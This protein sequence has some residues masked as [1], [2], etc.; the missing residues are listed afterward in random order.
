MST[1]VFFNYLAY[2]HI[3]ST[4]PLVAELVCRG[5]RVIYYALEEFQATIEDT[6]AIFRSY[7]QDFPSHLT[8]AEF[9]TAMTVHGL[10]QTSKWVLDNLLQEVRAINPDYIA[11][12]AF[13]PWGRYVAQVLQVPTVSIVSGLLMNTR[14]LCSIPSATLDAVHPLVTRYKYTARSQALA[15][16]L[17]K[18][19]RF[20]K[21]HF[22]EVLS[23]KGML[24]IVYTSKLFQPL[25]NSFDHRHFKFV[26][27]PILPRPKT[28]SFPFEALEKKPLIY[29]SLGTI[30]NKRE[31]FYRM[32]FEAFADKD[33]QIVMAIGHSVSRESLGAVPANFIVRKFV[34]QLEILQRTTLFITHGGMNSV[35]EALYYNVP[36]VVVP[37]SAADQ[38]WIAKRIVELG[39][40]KMLPYKK[41]TV[42]N[43]C[44]VVEEVLS[45]PTYAQA[46][47]RVGESLRAAGGCQTAVDE[48]QTFKCIHGIT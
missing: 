13:C 36:L 8:N 10:L 5:E 27:P 9:D 46:V 35:S 19:Y 34:P 40:G 20:K 44:R 12:E 18:K 30:F 28:I 21:P 17:S 25:A 15:H 3:N 48:I 37:Q 32:C 22:A 4:L 6:G 41:V 39:V 14:I 31:A 29:I 42:R 1:V 23:N 24:N 43:L 45:E 16:T 2:G 11:Y 7:G 38:P 47:A 33:W 26:G